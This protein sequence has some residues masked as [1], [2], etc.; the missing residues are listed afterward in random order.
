MKY[1]EAVERK[2]IGEGSELKRR[3]KLWRGIVDAHIRGR[4]DAIK[5]ILI[6]SYGNSVTEEFDKLLKE[7]RQKL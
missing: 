5:S 6:E 2:V 1:K 7:L 3:K 4:E